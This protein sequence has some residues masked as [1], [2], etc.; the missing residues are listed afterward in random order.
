MKSGNPYLLHNMVFLASETLL[1]TL[2]TY[3]K[4][5]FFHFEPYDLTISKESTSK[6][7]WACEHES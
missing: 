5:F 6:I 3:K 4:N 2:G 1:Y 7:W